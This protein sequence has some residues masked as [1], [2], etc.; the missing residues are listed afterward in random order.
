M[1]RQ[2][3]RTRRES[4]SAGLWERSRGWQAQLPCQLDT[5]LGVAP[6]L[7]HTQGQGPGDRP[8][9]QPGAAGGTHPA[10]PGDNQQQGA[11]VQ[12]VGA[13][14]GRAR[15]AEQT[16]RWAA[17]ACKSPPPLGLPD[18]LSRPRRPLL[19]AAP[20]PP[21]ATFLAGAVLKRWRQASWS[22]RPSSCYWRPWPAP[23]WRGWRCS[24]GWC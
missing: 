16:A 15:V 1:A 9:V 24:S 20:A 14:G 13:A 12:T 11:A 19:A 8:R 21:P 7:P 5:D 23:W 10:V 6:G 17:A 18:C 2:A 3:R 4:R 22:Q